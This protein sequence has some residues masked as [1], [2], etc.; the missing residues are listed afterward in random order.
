MKKYSLLLLTSILI[1]NNILF[2]QIQKRPYSTTELYSIARVWGFLKYYHP[3]V[4]QGKTNWDSVLLADLNTQKPLAKLFTDWFSYANTLPFDTSSK[5]THSEVCDSI[6]HRNFDLSWIQADRSIPATLKKSLA[7][8]ASDRQYIGTYYSKANL[9]RYSGKAENK[10]PGINLT[11]GYRLLNLFRAWNVI[12]YFYPYKYALDNKWSNVLRTFIP[13]FKTAERSTL[14]DSVLAKFSAN[15]DDSHT[16]VEPTLNYNIFGEYG[17]PFAFLYIDSLAVVTR[18][19]NEEACKAAGIQPGD[20][21]RSVNNV[22]VTT[23]FK[24]NSIFIPASNA[25]IKRRDVFFHLFNGSVDHMTISGYTKDNIPFTKTVTRVKRIYA[26]EWFREG[27]PDNPLLELNTATQQLEY[28]R[29]INNTGY[30]DFASLQPVHIDSIM[31]R[32][33]NT[34]SII[35]DMRGYS[36]NPG[37][38]KLFSYLFA[39]SA[40]WGKLSQ[41][42]FYAPGQFCYID[43]IISKSYKFIGKKNNNAYRGKVIVLINETTQ[44]AQEMWCMMFKKIPGVVFI[45]SQTS[46]ADGNMTP[47]PLTDGRTIIFSGVGIYY[48]DGKETQRVGIVP[49]IIVKPTIKDIQAGRDPLVEKAIQISG[50]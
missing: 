9:N 16:S 49:D 20:V 45:G 28:T 17:P 8:L 37:L 19:V 39:D 11:E 13:L 6:D 2:G 46:G 4:S 42:D 34:R 38:L 27:Y 7:K 35:F 3:A 14:Y 48:P 36:D 1:G 50:S 22:P 23:L 21:I 25:S 44:S 40:H 30:I 47:I 31:R 18:I 26:E 32:M 29:I 33:S 15:I 24:N 5:T 12:E 10:Y 43:N 41:P